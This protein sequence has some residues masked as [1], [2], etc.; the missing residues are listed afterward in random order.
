MNALRTTIAVAVAALLCLAAPARLSASEELSRAREL[1]RG[2]SYEEALTLLRSVG[3]D[4]AEAIE[5]HQY[6]VLCLIALDRRDDARQAMAVLISAAPLYQLPEEEASPRVRTM[7]ADV[8][9]SVLPGIVQR[10]Y[11]DAKAAFER[12]EADAADRFDRVLALLKDPIVA[13][14]SAFADLATVV[15]GFRDLSRAAAIR[16]ATSAPV[17]APAPPAARA[18]IVADARRRPASSVAIGALIPPVPIAQPV[19]PI[20]VREAREWDGEVEVVIDAAGKVVAARITRSVHPSYDAQLLRAARSWTYKPAT[21]DGV[22]TQMVKQVSIH[23][24]SRPACRPRVRGDC[25]P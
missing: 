15:T 11:G 19:P 24:D 5:A 20:Q 13:A 12:K 22:A 4:S 7:F 1:Y 16:P 23:L 25:R 8:R 21:R 2:A 6:R 14:D 18:E 9:T 3:G 10:A 17:A